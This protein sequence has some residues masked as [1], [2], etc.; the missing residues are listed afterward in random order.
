M[1]TKQENNDTK[2]LRLF[3][4]LLP[5]KKVQTRLQQWQDLVTGKKTPVENLHMTLF[6]LGNQPEK[7]LPV[8]KRFLD[9]VPFEPFDLIMD[10]IGFFPKI[11]L[12]W[13]GPTETPPSLS[14]LF[15]ETRKFLIPGY[16]KDKNDNF[17]PH[18]TLAR[19]STRPETYIPGS[20]HW[21]V[22]RVALMQ[23]VLNNTP[24]QHPQY[25][26]L[27][28]KSGTDPDRSNQT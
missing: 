8:F 13:A 7:H 15:Q 23:S 9:R 10:K 3:F 16:V 11:G 17:R 21:Q 22:K 14:Q 6:F 19:R 27:H 24:G 5:D 12:S 26:I 2:S 4:A 20:I 18:I 1:N 28:E 25:R